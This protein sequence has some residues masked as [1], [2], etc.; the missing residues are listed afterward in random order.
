MSSAQR[1]PINWPAT[2][3]FI[4]T[5]VPIFTVLPW[6][7]ATQSVSGWAWVWAFVLLWANG[8][9]IT[10]GYHRLWAHRAYQAHPLLKWIYA[11]FGGMALQNSIQIWAAT[12]RIH[13]QHVDHIDHDPYSAPRGF[14]Y[15]HIGWMLRDY[16]ASRLDYSNAADLLADPVVSFQ[17]RHY[18]AVAIG[19]NLGVVLLLGLA[20]GDVWGFLLVAGFLRIVANHHVTFFINSLAHWWGRQPYTKENTARDN[21]FLAFLTYGE[22]YHNFHHIFQWDYRNGIRWWQFDPTKWLIAAS[23]K[24]GLARDLK[25]VPEFKIQRAMLD[26]QFERAHED[27]AA[28]QA[29][30]HPR[31]AEWQ[32]LLEAELQTFRAT[33]GEWTQMQSGKFEA[34]KTQLQEKL[35]DR[36]E[37]SAM[38]TRLLIL[39]RSLKLQRRRVELLRAQLASYTLKPATA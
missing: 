10:A 24:L 19:M 32:K 12:H 39:E 2:V 36:W 37:H 11:L 26:R 25:R 23:E 27:L 7:L 21:D 3:M 5:T 17:H 22:G 6:Y 1:A 9:S 33:I 28:V 8:L 20:Y 29:P 15:S 31:L 34:A 35:H 13:H 14:W 16:P 30:H 18:L 38:R 4:L